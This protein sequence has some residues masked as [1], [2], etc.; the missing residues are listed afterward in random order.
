MDADAYRLFWILRRWVRERA[1]AANVP[2]YRVR[3]DYQLARLAASGNLFAA[4]W[5]VVAPCR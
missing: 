4:A 2:P 3:P 5:C 1:E